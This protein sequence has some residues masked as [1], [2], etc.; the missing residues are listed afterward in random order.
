MTTNIDLTVEEVAE[1]KALTSEAEIAAAVR[2]AM[3][4]Y[5]RYA[6][7]QQLKT[8]SGRIEMQDNWGQL[9]ALERRPPYEAPGSGPR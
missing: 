8:L 9:E 7:R 5:L 6:R 1:L 2:K 4:E 3:V